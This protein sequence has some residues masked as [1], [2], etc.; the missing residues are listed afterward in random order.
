M[1]TK[2]EHKLFVA[3][4]RAASSLQKLMDQGSSAD[5]WISIT[6]QPLQLDLHDGFL[7]LGTLFTK[8]Q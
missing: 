5:R 4:Y 2:V 7:G 1:F 6:G 8:Q 3:A